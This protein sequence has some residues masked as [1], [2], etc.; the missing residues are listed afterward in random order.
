MMKQKSGKSEKE[1]GR[2]CENYVFQ[3]DLYHMDIPPWKS[4]RFL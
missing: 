3:P 1:H 2:N 4:F